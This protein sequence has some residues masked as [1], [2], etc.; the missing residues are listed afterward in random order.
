[1]RTMEPLLQEPVMF[2]HILVATDGSARADRAVA[3]AL[4]LAGGRAAVTAILVAPDYGTDQYVEAM[5]RPEGMAQLRPRLIDAGR[6]RLAEVL[7]RHGEAAQRVQPVVVLADR[8]YEAILETAERL[9]CDL[10]VMA[11]RGHG[12]VAGALLGSQTQ[13][14]I[15]G[16]KMPVLVV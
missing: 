4:K 11:S 7:A 5:I 16:A 9:H 10:I 1:M 12:P 2:E 8:A 13:H 6:H 15:G 14:V 3:A